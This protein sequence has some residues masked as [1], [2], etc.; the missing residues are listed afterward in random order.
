MT[1][2]ILRSESIVLRGH[3]GPP[4]IP[5]LVRALFV[6][7]LGREP[8]PGETADIPLSP[9][10]NL[11]AVVAELTRSREFWERITAVHAEDFLRLLYHCLLGREPD[12]EGLKHYVS[13]IGNST[14][15]GIILS[16]IIGS[17]EFTRTLATQKKWPN[18]TLTYDHPCIVFLH[19]HK[20]A[21]T[22]IINHLREAFGENIFRDKEDSVQHYSPAFLSR[23]SVFAGHFNYDSIKYIPKRHKSIFTFVREPKS[24]LISFYYFLKAHEPSTPN[25]ARWDLAQLANVLKIEPFFEDERVRNTTGIAVNWN[26]MTRAIMGNKQWKEWRLSVPQMSR[27]EFE[28]TVANEIRPAILQRLKEF[29]F[30][31]LQEDFD[32]SVELLFDILGKAPPER[33]RSDN[34]LADLV[35]SDPNLKKNVEKEPVTPRLHATLDN[36]VQLDNIV[37]ELAVELYSERFGKAACPVAIP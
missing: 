37:Y 17:E 35:G 1:M 11:T 12:P 26:K 20:T 30:V 2:N 6:G 15:L 9:E 28:D 10:P 4:Y 33:K 25:Y 5:E 36:L 31:G 27:S 16:D 13:R 22:S 29:I 7:L 34:A 32:R 19:I 24:R 14:R 21:G 8:R 23:Y 3:E 18:P